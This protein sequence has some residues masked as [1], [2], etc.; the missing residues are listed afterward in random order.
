MMARGRD[1]WLLFVWLGILYVTFFGQ[2]NGPRGATVQ[3][4]RRYHD[5]PKEGGLWQQPLLA[6]RGYTRGLSMAPAPRS[7]VAV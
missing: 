2:Q 7:R 4:L 6:T 3:G 5:L 1:P